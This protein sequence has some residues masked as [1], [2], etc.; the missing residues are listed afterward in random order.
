MEEIAEINKSQDE[1]LAR[2]ADLAVKRAQMLKNLQTRG[3]TQD[4]QILELNAIKT[5]QAEEI[6]AIQAV[7]EKQAQEIADLKE[8][9]LSLQ[10]Q[11]QSECKSLQ[12]QQTDNNSS[13][14]AIIATKASKTIGIVSTILGAAGL[15][16]AFIQ[17][18]I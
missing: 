8:K 10:A 13:L 1:E 7:N 15:I 16:L 4:V 17:F 6:K 9:Y 3:Q 18:F 5:K 2:Q 14:E 11:M 12:T